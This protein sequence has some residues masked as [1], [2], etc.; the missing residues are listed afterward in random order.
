MSTVAATLL[1]T[2]RLRPRRPRMPER[3]PVGSVLAEVHDAHLT[4]GG[5]TILD[6]ASLEVR[7]GEV[8][9]LVGPNGA[10][11]STLLG[12]LTGDR[13][14]SSGHV[15]VHGAPLSSWSTTD[16]ALR[17]A[18]LTQDVAVSFPFTVREVVE[19]GRSPWRA[20]PL[21]ED[22]DAIIA[23]SL[24]ATDVAHLAG[25]SFT[26]LSGGERARAALARVLA[27]RTQLLLLDEPTAALDLR[28]QE[29]VLSL[30]R[31][32]ARAGGAVVV[33]VHDIGL[34]AAYADQ[35]TVLAGGRV[36][37]DGVPGDVLTPELLT[38]VY[39]HPVEVLEHPGGGA[40]II[41]PRR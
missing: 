14:P 1:D 16:L 3:L 36:V 35:V 32:H 12:V 26:T 34:A 33:V 41:L 30:A 38:E 15:T 22:D 29:L 25:R 20:T 31:E 8:R 19:M 7:A 9:A 24:E 39:E 17:R 11:K 10:G 2:V 21:E 5:S 23:E 13:K 6:G 28:H 37:G 4:L 18:V 40:P 27:Q